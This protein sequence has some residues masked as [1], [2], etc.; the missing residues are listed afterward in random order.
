M[1][2]LGNIVEDFSKLT[3]DQKR[4]APILQISTRRI[5]FNTLKSGSKKSLKIEISNKGIDPLEIRRVLNNNKELTVKAGKESLRSGKSTDI[6]V[7][8]D[9][10]GLA[11]GDYKKTFTLQTNDPDHSTIILVVEWKVQK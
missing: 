8:L 5:N 6:S 3:F 7:E 4:N 2:V 10:K 11:Q 9:T 1:I